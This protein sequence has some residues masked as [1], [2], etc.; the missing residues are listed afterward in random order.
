MRRL[1]NAYL[2]DDTGAIGRRISRNETPVRC[3]SS[4]RMNDLQD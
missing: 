3:A 1:G 4:R 2:L